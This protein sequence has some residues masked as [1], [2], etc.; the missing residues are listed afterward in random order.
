VVNKQKMRDKIQFIKEKLTRLSQINKA[1]DEAFLADPFLPDA[2]VRLLQ[3][4]IEAMIDIAGHIVAREQLGS[5][6]TY[7]E[8]FE[9]MAKAGILPRERLPTYINMVKFRNRAVHLYD[10]ISNE[11]ILKII[12]NNL[13]DFEEFI[14]YIVNS[15]L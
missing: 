9:L 6:K 13:Q 5:P 11:E 10:N 4:S 1:G 7:R 14:G 8:S 2:A 12:K 15:Y 3:V